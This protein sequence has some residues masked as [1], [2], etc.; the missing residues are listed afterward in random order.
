MCKRFSTEWR[1]IMLVLQRFVY[2]LIIVLT[3]NLII[4]QKASAMDGAEV[5]DILKGEITRTIPNSNTL[6]NQVKE[7]LSSITGVVESLHI[8]PSEGIAIK[9][10]LTPPYKLTS[11]WMNGTV[12]E[13]VMFISTSATYY[14]TLLIFTKEN[15][16]IAVH[17]ESSNLKS[18][19]Q[20]Y[21]LDSLKLN[22]TE[23]P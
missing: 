8:E 15:G 3:C 19:L 9:I 7:W 12:T 2:V 20:E 5:F 23:A 22:L 6:Q 10:P 1:L 21:K 11:N 16:F 4:T 17:F 14:P 18:F 13:I